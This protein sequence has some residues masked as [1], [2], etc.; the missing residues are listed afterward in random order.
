MS[1]L[2]LCITSVCSHLKVGACLPILFHCSPMC[3]AS[4]SISHDNTAL[5]ASCDAWFVISSEVAISTIIL[6]YL[7]KVI[8]GRTHSSPESSHLT[9]I[10]Y[11]LCDFFVCMRP[12]FTLS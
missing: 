5:L 6:I 2:V 3:G 10:V 9:S 8:V 12:L 1:S 4:I 7:D 11:V